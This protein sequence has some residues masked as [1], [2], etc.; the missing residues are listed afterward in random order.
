VWRVA[1]EDPLTREVVRFDTMA[2][3]F[4]FLQAQTGDP[5]AQGGADTDSSLDHEGSSNV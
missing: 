2:G 1:L 4:A 5:P 3:L